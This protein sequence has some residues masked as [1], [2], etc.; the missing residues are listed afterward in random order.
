MDSHF[1]SADFGDDCLDDLTE[2]FKAVLESAHVDT[3]QVTDEWTSLKTTIYNHPDWQTTLKDITWAEVNRRWGKGHDNILA[4]VDMVL[5]F[6]AS[7]AECERGFNVMKMIKSD[8]RSALNNTSINDLM[9]VLL[10]SST[11]TDFNPQRAIQ[12]WL[13]SGIRRKRPEMC[14][15]HASSYPVPIWKKQE[16]EDLFEDELEEEEGEESDSEFL[17]DHLICLLDCLPAMMTCLV[18]GL[19]EMPDDKP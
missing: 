3:T 13:K 16:D 5:T 6:P 12:L 18:K 2:H 7:T 17:S 15:S 19:T 14:D 9:C 4:V 10:E 1:F 8:W 11:I